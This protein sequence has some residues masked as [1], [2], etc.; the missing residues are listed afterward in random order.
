[1][2]DEMVWLFDYLSGH[3]FVADLTARLSATP[4]AQA[5]RPLM[6]I[7]RRRKTGCLRV[8]HHRREVRFSGQECLLARLFEFLVERLD[9]AVKLVKLPCS[10]REFLFQMIDARCELLDLLQMSRSRCDDHPLHT[11][12]FHFD[13]LGE[14]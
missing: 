4:L 14:L 8:L 1:M 13:H 11:L 5:S 10:F 3:A 6:N 2:D 12:V 9:H 7:C